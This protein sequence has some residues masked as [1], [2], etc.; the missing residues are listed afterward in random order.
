MPVVVNMQ[1][2][3]SIHMESIR[4]VRNAQ[5]ELLDLPFMRAL[6][7]GDQPEIS[8]I[9]KLKQIL[10]DIPQTFDLVAN[11]TAQLSQKWP[12]ELPTPSA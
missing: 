11:T 3:K 10:R 8:R 6:E 4:V 2:A 12:K 1:K 7:S 5:L 9:T